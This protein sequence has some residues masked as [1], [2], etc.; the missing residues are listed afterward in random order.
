MNV[1][2]LRLQQPASDL[3]TVCD[4]HCLLQEGEGHR[5]TGFLH[6]SR[7]NP[8]PPPPPLAVWN[9]A[10]CPVTRIRLDICISETLTTGAVDA[11]S[12]I[13]FCL[14]VFFW[15][16][17]GF[18]L[19]LYR[20]DWYC[21]GELHWRQRPEDV[22]PIISSHTVCVCSETPPLFLSRKKKKDTRTS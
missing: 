11:G 12:I 21:T 8:P 18:C 3:L 6:A 17:V 22:W 19:W 5:L 10:S 14:F 7:M 20:K 9:T 15:G 13:L 16:G 1:D 2:R 4:V